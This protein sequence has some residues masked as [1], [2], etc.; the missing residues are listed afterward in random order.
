MKISREVKIGVFAT[1]C[2]AA[3]FWGINF[4]K[5][6]NV[7]SPN[8]IYYA[9]FDQVDGLENTNDVLING[10]KVGVV[11]KIEFEKGNTGRFIVSLLIGKKYHIPTNVVAKMISADI[12]GGK[13]IKL[14]YKASNEYIQPGDTLKSQI[15]TGLIDQ[16]GHQMV[17]VK[18]K[19]ERMMVEMEKTLK[20]MS[21][22]FNEN[23]RIQLNQSFSN[24]NKSLYNVNQV[25]AELDT[26]LKPNGTLRKMF[27]N[28]ESISNNLKN[29]N[30]DLTNI[31]KNFSSISDSISR[32]RVVAT[33]RQL[34]SSISQF[35]TIVTKINAGE[36]TLGN[37]IK[38]DT[39]YFNLENASRGL[40]LLIKDI[41]SNPKRY[42]NFSV[43]DLSRTKY[44]EEKKPA[45]R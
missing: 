26:M 38:N 10:F 30:K 24:L 14:E 8:Y 33:F 3:M 5:G 7:L 32:I 36:G 27:T 43:I 45:S 9:I 13:A 25:T 20:I 18:E 34:D 1:L 19:A 11:K 42:I 4:L 22:V 17:P 6:K 35:N 16:L 23:N 28:V 40:D 12:M 41:K 21:E 15:E 2:L 44:V 39:L 29:N 37:L 31:I